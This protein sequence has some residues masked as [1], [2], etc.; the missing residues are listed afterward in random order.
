MS[1][2]PLDVLKMLEEPVSDSKYGHIYKA[3]TSQD[4]GISE[5]NELLTG[6]KL[7]RVR[8][9]NYYDGLEELVANVGNE[10]PCTFP[11]EGLII[12]Q[13]YTATERCT[14]T[15]WETGL[16]DDTELF[17]ERIS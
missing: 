16:C 5:S 7:E 15:D 4:Y 3:V 17:I 1:N 12:G 11:E 13:Y 14:S 2:I 9:G 10:F 6:I 8:R